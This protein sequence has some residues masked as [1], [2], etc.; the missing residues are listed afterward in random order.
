KG[1]DGA[2]LEAEAVA[3][4]LGDLGEARAQV[5]EEAALHARVEGGR[6]RAEQQDR[7]APVRRDEGAIDDA[8]RR[9]RRLEAAH[10]ALEAA[11]RIGSCER[12][13]EGRG[14]RGQ[15]P[16]HLAC[17]RAQARVREALGEVA[18]WL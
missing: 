9:P 7:P 16:A 17:A 3:A 13:E 8:Q 5:G 10:E 4:R 11:E 6:P 18:L 15:A 12:R 1:A 2:E 14:G